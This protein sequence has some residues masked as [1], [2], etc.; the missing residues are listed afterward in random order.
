MQSILYLAEYSMK[1]Y[2]SQLFS[3]YKL[4]NDIY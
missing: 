3:K 1:N 2:I 4:G